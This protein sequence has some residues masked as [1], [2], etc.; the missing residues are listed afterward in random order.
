MSA[1]KKSTLKVIEETYC[2]IGFLHCSAL[3]RTIIKLLP[4]DISYMLPEQDI[5]LE[6]DKS[7]L[8]ASSLC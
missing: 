8:V 5:R 2:P 6:V 4:D 3:R 7:G 1:A